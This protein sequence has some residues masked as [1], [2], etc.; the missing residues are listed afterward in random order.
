C[1]AH[2]QSSTGAW[3]G[4]G[5]CAAKESPRLQEMPGWHRIRGLLAVSDSGPLGQLVAL[6]IGEGADGDH[7]QVDQRP[8][9]QAAEG[10]DLQDAGAD[11]ADVEA[12]DAKHAEEEAQQKG[13]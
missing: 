10:D 6:L 7:D 13:R 9:A 3:E 1:T 5:Y 4:R 12:V 8:D 2:G 11:L